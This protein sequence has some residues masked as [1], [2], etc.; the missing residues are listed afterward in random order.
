MRQDAL[1]R[2]VSRIEDGF[3]EYRAY[4]AIHTLGERKGYL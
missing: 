1:G 4:K 3:N 2:T